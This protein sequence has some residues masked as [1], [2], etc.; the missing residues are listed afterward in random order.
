MVVGYSHDARHDLRGDHVYARSGVTLTSN[1]A[2]VSL[3][4]VFTTWYQGSTSAS[5]GSMFSLGIPFTIQNGSEPAR[6]RIGYAYQLAR[7]FGCSHGRV[8][9]SFGRYRARVIARRSHGSVDRSHGEG[10]RRFP[11]QVHAPHGLERGFQVT[12]EPAAVEQRRGQPVRL[13]LSADRPQAV[14]IERKLA[15]PGPRS[16]PGYGSPV[17][18]ARPPA[19]GSPPHAP[20]MPG[21]RT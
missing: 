8:L 11:G 16:P 19:A 2:T 9:G 10:P 21:P 5:F 7:Q 13:Q 14:R 1:S 18:A 4:Q 20:G 6:I 3:S 15:T 12:R 17:P